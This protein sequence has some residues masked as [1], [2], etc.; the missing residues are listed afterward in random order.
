MQKENISDEEEVR[1]LFYALDVTTSG[2]DD[3]SL[4]DHHSDLGGLWYPCR[5]G[6]G[7]SGGHTDR[8]SSGSSAH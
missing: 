5:A 8:G 6:S 2:M 7:P 1:Q 3:Q 4:G